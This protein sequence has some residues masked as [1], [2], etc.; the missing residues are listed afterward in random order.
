MDPALSIVI[1]VVCVVLSAFFSATETAFS[2]LNRIR[3]RNMSNSNNKKVKLVVKLSENF[4]M[5]IST[6]LIGNNIV[7]ILAATMG[8]ILFASIFKDN[9]ALGGTVSTI[10][11][12][13]VILIFGEITP[14]TLAKQSPEFFAK[15]FA[16]VILL[17][18]YILYPFSKLFSYF[19]LLMT[20]IF[21]AKDK[22]HITD[23]ELI[24]Y[25]D[26]AENEGGID[27]FEGDLIRSAIEFDDVTVGDILTP[28]VDVNAIELK[29]PIEDVIKLFRET[30]FSRLP[31][32]CDTVDT[33]IG[34][35]NEKDC[36]KAFIDEDAN[37]EKV[38]SRNIIFVPATTKISVLLRR[39]QKAK[40]HMAIVVDEFGGTLGIVTMEDILEEL[41]GEIWDEHDEVVEHFLKIEDDKFEVVGDT[42]LDDFFEFFD[43]DKDEDDYESK[44]LSGFIIEMI[45]VLPLVDESIEF[46]NLTITIKDVGYH[47]IDKVQVIVKPVVE[48]DED[49]DEDE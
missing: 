46:E 24:T 48:K 22:S 25:I 18:F 16:P 1:I 27:E 13:V 41:V 44:T 11:T 31:V 33:I 7:N 20:K 26:V 29:T 34:I 21:K 35:I 38:L 9:Q 47:K 40:I 30:G 28:R 15:T 3:L 23:E 8:T 6:I 10:V 4:D 43:I 32:Y 17:M 39:L 19:Q 37:V 2:S 36:Y 14:K 5:L 12:T 49:D 42:D 45:G